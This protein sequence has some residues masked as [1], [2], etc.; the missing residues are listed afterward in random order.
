MLSKTWL[1][2]ALLL[3]SGVLFAQADSLNWAADSLLIAKSHRFDFKDWAYESLISRDKSWQ[4]FAWEIGDLYYG[5]YFHLGRPDL[6]PAMRSGFQNQGFIFSPGLYHAYFSSFYPT[7]DDACNADYRN[8]IYPFEPPCSSVHALLGDYEHRFAKVSLAKHG[9]FS[10]SGLGY[11]GDL[12]VQNGFWADQMSAETSHKHYLSLESGK[13]TIEAE[14]AD[15]ERDISMA[16]L[17]PVYWQQTGFPIGHSYRQIYAAL[18]HPLFRLA[19]M[20]TNETARSNRFAKTLENSSTQLQLNYDYDTG[21]NRYRALYEH[22][23]NKS[24]LRFAQS[25]NNERYA[26]KVTL[27]FDKYMPYGV[28][29]YADCLDWERGKLALD[30]SYPLGAFNFGVYGKLLWGKDT[31]P[32]T[33]Q[34]I[35]NASGEFEL[36]NVKNQ[37]EQALYLSYNWLGAELSLAAGSK[38]IVQDADSPGF[39]REAN[40][41]L[42]KIGL[43]ANII[44]D[45]WELTANQRW[46]WTKYDVGLCE[47]PEFRFFGRQEVYYNLPYNNTLLGGFAVQGH[48]GY[49]AANVIN[50][51]LI[52]A[53]TALDLWLG[54]RIDNL[55]EL[56]GGFRNLLSSTLYGSMP[57]PL[58]AYAELTW[59]YFN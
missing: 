54:F 11:Q 57:V 35:Y 49:Y 8:K 34:D 19:A 52:E 1:V 27:S 56:K 18:N 29:L 48:S 21:V 41:P 40:L 59:F 51:V 38:S 43:D 12:L 10:Y 26:D 13:W 42:V 25:F 28:S 45:N 53:S 15:W 20:Q 47:S 5:G 30:A 58:S 6:S 7:R 16:D 36:L 44:W 32:V 24:N 9:L 50:P 23:F 17:L 22:S 33:A 2:V 4:P 14:Y 46:T 55:F 39:D 31:T 3:C 37:Q